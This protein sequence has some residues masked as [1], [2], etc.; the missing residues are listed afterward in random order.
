MTE[1]APAGKI[2]F[3]MACGKMST[4]LSS[5]AGGWDE[6][7]AMNSIAIDQDRRRP[8]PEQCEQFAKDRERTL[9]SCFASIARLSEQIKARTLSNHDR[10]MIAICKK[11]S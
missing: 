1:K 2:W 11:N 5:E 10:K 3:C 8:T 9:E 7:C 6:S 4:T